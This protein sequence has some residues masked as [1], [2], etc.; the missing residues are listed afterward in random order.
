MS[1]TAEPNN[2]RNA[3]NSMI[4]NIAGKSATAGRQATAGTPVVVDTVCHHPGSL[5]LV[6]NHLFIRKFVPG[7]FNSPSSK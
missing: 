5:T 4:I 2:T 6:A 3:N 7:V 1:I